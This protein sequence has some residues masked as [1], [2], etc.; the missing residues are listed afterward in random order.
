MSK[1]DTRWLNLDSQSLQNLGGNL[2]VLPD[3]AGAIERTATGINVKAA[4]VVESMLA[5]AVVAAFAKLADNE[6]VGGQWDFTQIPSTSVAPSSGNHLVNKAYADSLASGL[7][8]KA[9]VRAAT[10][11]NITLSG[12]FT[13]DGVVL[14]AGDRVLVKAQ[15][16]ASQNGIYTVAVGAWSRSADADTNAEVTSG[17]FTFVEEGT[18]N[19]GTGWVLTTQGAIVLGTT[20]LTF[21]QFS[22]AAGLTAGAGLLATGSTWDIVAA[23]DSIIVNA[24]SI[25]VRVD[26]ATIEVAGGSVGLRVKAGGIGVSHISAAIAGNGLTGGA[27][28]ALSVVAS[29][30]IKGGVCEINGD[31]LDIDYSPTNY[32]PSAGGVSSDAEHL[33]AHL[34]G[35]DNALAAIPQPRTQLFT[36]AGGDITAKYIT[37]TAAPLTANRVRLTVRGGPGQF[38]GQ[39]FA[40]DGTNTDRLTWNGYNLDG[41]LIAGD[42]LTV[43]YEL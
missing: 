16:T 30:L 11:S 6:T 21:T 35:I 42:Q 22:G 38:Y 3:P 43:E 12:E 28:S 27:G 31:Q 37:L 40:M 39:D 23:D 36:L 14:L 29:T 41:Q 20:N 1:L 13:H 4:S 10:V 5:A 17:M 33:S 7:D 8:V 2:A 34:A 26:G 19:A 18:T 15:T 24:D 25:Q 9:S 32:T